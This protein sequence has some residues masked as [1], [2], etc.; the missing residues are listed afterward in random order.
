MTIN[1]DKPKKARSKEDHE[2][3]NQSDCGVPGTFVPNMSNT[4][5]KKWKGK[6][7]G[8]RSGHPQIEIRKDSFVIIVSF[9]GYSY[10]F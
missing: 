1:W 6:V 7:V 5:M 10:K 8:T 4:D 2:E 3:M 9:H